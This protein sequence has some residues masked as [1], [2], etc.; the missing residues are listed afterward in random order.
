MGDFYRLWVQDGALMGARFDAALHGD[1]DVPAFGIVGDLRTA[2]HL[3]AATD[4][5]AGADILP[6]LSSDDEDTAA[7]ELRTMLELGDSSFSIADLLDSGMAADMGDN[8]VADARE[9][10]EKVR[11]NVA[12]LLSLSED[13]PGL[14]GLLTTAWSRVQTQVNS[15]FGTGELDLGPRPREDDIMD[16]IDDILDALSSGPAF[17]AATMEDG[18]GVFEDAALSEADALKAFDA[19]ESQATVVFGTTGPTRYG[20]ITATERDTATADLDYRMGAS[21]GNGDVD[22]TDTT[23]VDES[24]MGLI[25][26]F[27]YSTIDDV[28]RVWHVATTGSA[29]YEGGTRAVSGDGQLFAGDIAIEVRFS[30]DRVSGLVTN[31]RS[32]A[33]DPWS[34]QYGEVDSIVLATATNLDSNAHWSTADAADGT[35]SA[36]IT[37]APR[38]GSPLPQPIRGSFQGQLLGKGA[39]DDPSANG[40]HAHGTW[41][42]GTQTNSG[43]ANYLAGG[44]GAERVGEVGDG[45]RPGT[46]DGSVHETVVTSSDGVAEADLTNSF[47]IDGGNL[48]VTM[49]RYGRYLEATAAT[50]VEDPDDLLGDG[51]TTTVRTV[52]GAVETAPAGS[53][54]V[55]AL[56]ADELFVLDGDLTTGDLENVTHELKQSLADIMANQQLDR[57]VN[58]PDK[59]L[60][61]V[62]KEL[63]TARGDL[64]I[65]QS[66][67]IRNTTAEE[68]AWTKVQAAL[69]RIFHHVPPKLAEAYNDDDA[70]GLIDQALDAFSSSDNLEDALDRDGRGI[71]NDVTKADGTTLPGAALIWGR[72]EVQMK[73]HGGATDYTRWGVWRV[74][75]DRYAARD[76]WTQPA[77]GDAQGNE[78]GSYA[79]SQL[80]PTTWADQNDPGFPGSGSA[81]FMGGTTAIQATNFLDGD[82]MVTAE[83]DSTWDGTDTDALG[84]LSMRITNMADVDGDPLLDD[85]GAEFYAL[86]VTG[87]EI[88]TNADNQV[89]FNSV[90]TSSGTFT[91]LTGVQG[92]TEGTL[93]GGN[94]MGKFVGQDIEGPLGVI[95]TYNFGA[96][97]FTGAALRGSFGADRA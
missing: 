83:W 48:V 89:I 56:A 45:Q 81:V 54:A 53:G 69:L 61:I 9:G 77:V 97:N 86:V 32:T 17:A 1:S 58:G 52:L 30:T 93:D 10:I 5:D 26:A 59:Q 36:R 73:T 51:D 72:Q 16:E 57:N 95:G 43:S 29:Y 42:V 50:E 71:F 13:P 38:A 20:A 33:G 76:A 8:F 94:T 68:T 60:G 37:F 39:S 55:V 6:V 4:D 64:A 12:A 90:A 47:K 35:G 3:T 87:V 25:G 14:S 46:D 79:Y 7:N 22:D 67:N 23:E 66:L 74:R 63:E 80:L 62:V 18:D 24:E 84:T 11:G 21:L 28:Q 78:S 40:T 85:T 91:E 19:A 27:S 34:F 70:L 82:I 41:S 31:L 92:L 44:F 88:R 65:L 75:T 96:S 49:N 2:G 15:V